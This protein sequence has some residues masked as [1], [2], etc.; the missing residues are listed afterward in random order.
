[1]LASQIHTNLTTI[2]EDQAKIFSEKYIATPLS[3]IETLAH[4]DTIY[5]EG[6]PVEK[7]MA[8]LLREVERNRE[9]G[10]LR[11]IYGD[12][13][14]FLWYTDGRSKS[15]KKKEWVQM[16]LKGQSDITPPHTS[17]RDYIIYKTAVPIF[18]EDKRVIGIIGVNTMLRKCQKI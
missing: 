13:S 15:G 11:G 7:K 16:A 12:K 5:L 3:N 17:G 14:G 1:M 2:V 4:C 10:W 6:I 8:F 9:L 18:D